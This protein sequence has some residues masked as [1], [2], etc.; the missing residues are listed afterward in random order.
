VRWGIQSWGK[1]KEG[2]NF[3]NLQIANEKMEAEG[4]SV[5]SRRGGVYF[6]VERKFGGMGEGCIGWREGVDITSNP[7]PPLE[8]Q[9][10]DG[11]RMQSIN[12][13]QKKKKRGERLI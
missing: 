12:L 9:K 2:F 6:R 3:V 13:A 11:P 5:G 8:G 4:E 7:C 10:V 1:E